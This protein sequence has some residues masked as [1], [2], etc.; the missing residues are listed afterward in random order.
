M[1]WRG[2]GIGLVCERGGVASQ[3]DTDA[4]FDALLQEAVPHVAAV[5]EGKAAYGQGTKAT[6]QVSPNSRRQWRKSA[7]S[8][9]T[10]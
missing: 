4:A 7:G 5:A 9:A 1:I 6:V 10:A 8:G 3:A 2:I